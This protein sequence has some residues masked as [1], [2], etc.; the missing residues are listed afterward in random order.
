MRL[1]LQHDDGYAN[2]SN[3]PAFIMGKVVVERV[4]M[5]RTGCIVCMHAQHG[6]TRFSGFPN[7]A[8][9]QK[10]SNMALGATLFNWIPLVNVNDM[11]AE[12]SDGEIGSGRHFENTTKRAETEG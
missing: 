12:S 9:E 10:E 2:G 6:T 5:K 1:H 11:A 8:H 3:D 7:H 4:A